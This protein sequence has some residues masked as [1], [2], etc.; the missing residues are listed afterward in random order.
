MIIFDLDGFQVNTKPIKNQKHIQN[1]NKI[2][3][4]IESLMIN[5]IIPMAGHGKRFVEMGYDKPKPMID[6]CGDPMIKRVID[7]LTSKK[8]K[9][10]FI[11][12]ALQEH[13]DNG[14]S[15][16]LENYGIIIPLKV[17]TEGA[18]CTTLMALK[19]INNNVPSTMV[20]QPSGSGVGLTMGT[21]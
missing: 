5:I 17:V 6:V 10:N 18:A 8:V 16:Y 7:S 13:L 11:F 1:L 9:C 19:Q 2:N 3:D 12:I 21:S 20:K 15:K 4:I 14:L